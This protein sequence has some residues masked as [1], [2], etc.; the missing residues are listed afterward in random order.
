MLHFPSNEHEPY[1]VQEFPA[2]RAHRVLVFYDGDGEVAI[3]VRLAT[4]RMTPELVERLQERMRDQDANPVTG[5]GHL[6][7]LPSEGRSDP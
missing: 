6:S 5:S 4:R 2:F 3:E 1:S 7:L